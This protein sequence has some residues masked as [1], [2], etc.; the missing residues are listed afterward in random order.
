MKKLNPISFLAFL[1]V[2]YVAR[3]AVPYIV[4]PLMVL[5]VPFFLYQFAN[6]KQTKQTIINC[7]KI[8]S[9]IVLLIVIELLAIFC[10]VNP[11]KALPLNFLKEIAFISMFMFLI[12]VYVQNKSDFKYFI[13]N[14]SKFFILFSIIIAVV[15]LWK[16]FY[17]PTFLSYH[18]FRY[19]SYI[20]SC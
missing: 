13:Q 16:F 11:F 3:N 1:I 7:V 4:Y 5:L 15:G 19:Q 9:P 6:I 12:T 20:K 14:I 2:M 8:F 10:F 18:K 17:A